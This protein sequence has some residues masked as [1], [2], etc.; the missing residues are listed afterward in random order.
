[1]YVLD[2][3]AYRGDL[4]GCT[5]KFELAAEEKVLVVFS[6]NGKQITQ[7]EISIHNPDRKP[8][9]PYIGMA[10]KGIRVLAKVGVNISPG[11]VVCGK[12]FRQ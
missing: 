11:S 10:H 7:E 8:L 12:T 6:L 2:A 9:Y 5:V 3:M 1:M 4:I